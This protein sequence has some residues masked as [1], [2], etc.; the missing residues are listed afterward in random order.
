MFTLNGSL[1]QY[2]NYVSV[3]LALKKEETIQLQ[4]MV[5]LFLTLTSSFFIPQEGVGPFLPVTALTILLNCL[6]L[7]SETLEVE[8]LWVNLQ[9]LAYSGLQ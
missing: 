2:E 6:S 4:L 1:V 5:S 8:S 9:C 3:K 7:K